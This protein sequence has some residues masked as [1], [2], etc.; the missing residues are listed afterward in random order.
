MK[1]A[2][3]K[4]RMIR[5]N[6]LA[7]KKNI[8]TA[9]DLTNFQVTGS[10]ETVWSQGKDGERLI[11]FDINKVAGMTF[12]NGTVDLDI[13]GLQIGSTVKKVENGTDISMREAIKVVDAEKVITKNKASGSVG[14]EIKWIYK[15]DKYGNPSKEDTYSQAASATATS[16]AYD[17][18]TKEI[19]LPTGKFSVGD[20]VIVDYNPTFTKYNELTNQSDKFSTTGEVIVDAWFTDLCD[21]TD[22]PLQIYCAKGKFSGEV[23][24][25]FGD[26]AAV[27]NATID[28][29]TNPCDTNKA[30]WVLRDYDEND[31]VD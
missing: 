2:L 27:Q 25:A 23:D 30:L 22:V 8:A 19:T 16:F 17:P 15:A 7:T 13:M 20:T 28:A 6:D 11:G 1:Y 29:I 3:K 4:I 26:A 9:T 31:I 24:L 21:E 5:V 18:A 14:N 10:Q 12:T